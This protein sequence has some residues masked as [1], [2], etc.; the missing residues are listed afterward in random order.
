MCHILN[1]QQKHIMEEAEKEA[2]ARP[3][4]SVVGAMGVLHAGDATPEGNT[5]GKPSPSVR[6]KVRYRAKQKVVV[7]K[8]WPKINEEE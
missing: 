6:K 1:E 4:A 5:D 8:P 2:W 7:A 3:G